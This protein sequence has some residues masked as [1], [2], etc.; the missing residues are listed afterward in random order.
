MMTTTKITKT[1]NAMAFH[2]GAMSSANAKQPEDLDSH[3]AAAFLLLQVKEMA[4]DEL[5]T[6]SRRPQQQQRNKV[7]KKRKK[8]IP[9][10]LPT[11]TKTAKNTRIHDVLGPTTTTTTATA[12]VSLPGSPLLLSNRTTTR[13]L[14][15]KPQLPRSTSAANFLLPP[16]APLVAPTVTTTTITTARQGTG[17]GTAGG[18]HGPPGPLQ[19][20][21]LLPTRRTVSLGSSSEDLPG[22]LLRAMKREDEQQTKL[23]AAS[24]GT[25]SPSTRMMDTTSVTSSSISSLSTSSSYDTTTSS[26][27]SSSIGPST[28]PPALVSPTTDRPAVVHA[29]TSSMLLSAL[30]PSIPLQQ[31]KGVADTT[32]TTTATNEMD[33]DC[34]D[35]MNTAVAPPCTCT[36]PSSTTTTTGRSSVVVVV[37]VLRRK[38]SWKT[39]PVLEQFLLDHRLQYLAYS[40][41]LNYTAEQKR[42]NNTLTNNLISLAA[43]S[44]LAFDAE[45]FT[46]AAI[47]DRIR[48]FYKSHVQ[49]AKKKKRKAAAQAHLQQQHPAS[50]C[51]SSNS[52]VTASLK[53]KKVK[54][55]KTSTPASMDAAMA[56]VHDDSQVDHL[57][58]MAV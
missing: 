56:L 53:R 21:W 30:L 52:P 16:P 39:H 3:R 49:A 15:Q 4:T 24:T 34:S 29:S 50:S 27:S 2:N 7:E 14:P 31:E 40:A 43:E 48:C 54:V 57:K 10:S 58:S 17:T 23:A 11:A 41:K 18:G 6:S 8:K 45:H 36:S 25:E 26:L 1:T 19:A 28:M 20:Q 5:L 42:Y 44:G 22:L 32:S 13:P 46:F 38:F 35:E 37:T 33:T 47:R 51:S 12:A 9:A 55:T